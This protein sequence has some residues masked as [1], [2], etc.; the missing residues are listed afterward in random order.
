MHSF[1]DVQNW[2]LQT[3]D[4]KYLESFEMWSWKNTKKIP[5]TDRVKKEPVLH[6][7]NTERNILHIIKRRK[8][9]RIRFLKYVIEG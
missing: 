6:R 9:N 2:T 7:I 8:T 3:V 4:Q 1:Y 5:F